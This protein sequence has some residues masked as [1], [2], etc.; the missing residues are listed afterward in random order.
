MTWETPQT[1]D[2]V[3]VYFLQYPTMPGR[4]VHLQKQS[5]TGTW[6]DF[7]VTT[8]PKDRGNPYATATFQLPA[9]VTADKIRIVNLLDL[10][11]VDVR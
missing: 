11:E 4:K 6:E 10:F 1:F 7:A 3:V 9:K 8:I 5:A 2:K